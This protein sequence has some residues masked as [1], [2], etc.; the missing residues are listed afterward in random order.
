[1]HYSIKSFTQIVNA[2]YTFNTLNVVII[3]TFIIRI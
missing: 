1:M 3:F 2:A